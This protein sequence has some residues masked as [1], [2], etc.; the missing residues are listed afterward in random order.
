MLINKAKN[1]LKISNLDHKNDRICQQ[2][3]TQ[4]RIHDLIC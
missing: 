3:N 4:W 2:N 1:S